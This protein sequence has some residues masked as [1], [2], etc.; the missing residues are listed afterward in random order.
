MLDRATLLVVNVVLPVSFLSVGWFSPQQRSLYHP[1]QGGAN[2][3]IS[4]LQALQLGGLH[5]C[6]SARNCG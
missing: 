3:H 1:S 5:E 2:T 6:M 4:L